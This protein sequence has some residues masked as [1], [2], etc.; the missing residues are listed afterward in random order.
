[1]YILNSCASGSSCYGNHASYGILSLTYANVI[2]APRVNILS[3]VPGRLSVQLNVNMSMEGRLYCYAAP[4]NTSVSSTL[5]V[6]QNGAS[7]LVLTRNALTSV[8]VSDLSPSTTYDVYVYAESLAGQGMDLA[9]VRAT[10]R[11][12]A[13]YC[14]SSIV[15]VTK[16]S[17][18]LQYSASTAT[19]V[20]SNVFT[21]S[22]DFNPTKS[23]VVNVTVAAVGCAGGVLSGTSTAVALPSSFSFTPGSLTRSGSFV[24]HGSVGCYVVTAFPFR[25][26]PPKNASTYVS[27]FSSVDQLSDPQIA[28]VVFSSDGSMLLVNFDSATNYGAGVVDS[29]YSEFQCDKLLS[30]IGAKYATCKWTSNRSLVA[31]LFGAQSATVGDTVTLLSSTVR[32]GVSATTSSIPVF[33]QP[34]VSPS[35]PVVALSTAKTIGPCDD[36]VLDPTASSGSGGR[37]WRKVEWLVSGSGAPANSIRAITAFLNAFY[38]ASTSSVIRVPKSLFSPPGTLTIT[39]SLESFL[40][41]SSLATKTITLLSSASIPRVK[42]SG[43]GQ[44]SMYRKDVLRLFASAANSACGNATSSALSYSWKVYKDATYLPSIVST[45]LNDRMFL[46][47]AYSLEALTKY[48]VQ[49]TVTTISGASNSD[50]VFVYVGRTGVQAVIAGGSHIEVS[51]LN[52]LAI[53]ASSS[54]DMDY[55][56]ATTLMY[57]WKCFVSYPTYGSPCQLS[58]PNTAVLAFSAGRLSSET[59]YNFTVTTVSPLDGSFSISSVAIAVI[60]QPLPSIKFNKVELKYNIGDR[61]V[62]SATVNSTSSF[63]AV[64]SCPNCGLNLSSISSSPTLVSFS[65]G[66]QSLSLAISANSLISGLT[67]RFQLSAGY[68]T[69]TTVLASA[70]ASIVTNGPPYGGSLS[71]SPLEGYAASTYY[72][73]STY[74]WIDAPSDYP[75]QY[76]MGYYSSSAASVLFVQSLNQ[77]SYI[78]TYLGQGLASAGYEVMC[79]AYSSDI[80][81][82]TANASAAVKVFPPQS[83]DALQSAL[84]QQLDVAEATLDPDLTSAVVNAAS[85]SLNSANC[86]LAPDCTSLNRT[87]CSFVVQTCGS[88]IDGYLGIEGPG[89]TPCKLGSALLSIGSS[90]LSH[91]DC[92]SHSCLKGICTLSAKL[93]PNNCTSNAQGVCVYEDGNGHPLDFCDA[94]DLSCQSKCSCH[95]GWFGRDCSLTGEKYQSVVGMREQMCASYYSATL[96]QV[97][98]F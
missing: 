40:R 59:T 11:R 91:S 2:V 30:F 52:Y 93:C 26:S 64:W 29:P 53:D 28:S 69:T 31:V 62:L 77:M 90:C 10:R 15:F 35:F 22:L 24:V 88:C 9:S 87:P 25:G 32:P 70:S 55:P 5:Y 56:T 17:S 66:L 20:D 92:V 3:V 48:T 19:T 78:S 50:T 63:L 47:P 6:R 33:I 16:Y 67:Y 41:A 44:V 12:V 39:L 89:N 36:I 98:Y 85:L 95:Q 81:G 73:L 27:I 72:L 23:L 71:V 80:Y 7:I 96:V 58:L 43:A 86:S 21:F 97:R 54:Y 1:M 83:L 84:S 4:F 65:G 57:T 79:V 8:T 82:A 13:T 74:D 51:A 49:V 14:C 42:I 46:L 18:L 34:P 60:S 45:S 37:L 94:N 76:S 75:L 68:G 38:N 61:T